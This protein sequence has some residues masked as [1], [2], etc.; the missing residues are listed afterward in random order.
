VAI[1]A[2]KE[3]D[4]AG[5]VY[6]LEKSGDDNDNSWRQSTQLVPLRDALMGDD[7]FGWSTAEDENLV[8][9]GVEG[10]SGDAAYLFQ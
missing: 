4:Q 7:R 6:V 2:F 5:L 9:I 1:A 8:M 10:C 3:Y